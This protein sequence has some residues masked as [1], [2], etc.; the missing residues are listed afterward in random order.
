MNTFKRL[1]PMICDFHVHTGRFKEEHYYS[2]EEVYKTLRTLGIGRWVVS[3]LSTHDRDFATARDEILAMI[4]LAPEEAIPLLWV[5]PDMVHESHDL[6]KY[7]AVPFRGIKIHGFADPWDPDGI[8]LRQ[9]FEAASARELPIFIHT[10]GR[11]ESDAAAYD[12]LC[13]QFPHVT[14][15]LA[16]G[17]PI[18]QTIQVLKNNPNVYV[19]TAFMPLDHIDQLRRS[20]GDE[21]ILFGTDFPIDT[22]YYPDQPAAT[23]YEER[24]EKLVE[25]FGEEAFLTW[26]HENVGRIFPENAGREKYVTQ[27]ELPLRK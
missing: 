18:D 23:L 6:K 19:D 2:P 8:P 16:H 27:K 26:T 25:A 22:F 3:S 24:I 11:P 21:R 20:V 15:V 10:G 12:K 14:V 5:T 1:A 7:D 13:G 4:E 9:V 17:R